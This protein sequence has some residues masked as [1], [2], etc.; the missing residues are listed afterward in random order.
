MPVQSRYVPDNKSFGKFMMTKD[1]GDAAVRSAEAIKAKAVATAPFDA[2]RDDEAPHYVDQFGV[3][4]VVV[5]ISDGGH[6]NP[7]QSAEVYN[8]SAH[9]AAVE[10]GNRANGGRG[11]H[12]LRRAGGVGGER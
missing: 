9:A 5:T 12:V 7:R 11:Q 4:R 8:D 1:V 6:A 2:T 10:F 3:D